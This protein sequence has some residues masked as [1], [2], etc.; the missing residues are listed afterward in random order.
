MVK[1]IILQGCISWSHAWFCNVNI[2]IEKIM[3]NEIQGLKKGF[4]IWHF[5]I[6]KFSYSYN[7]LLQTFNHKNIILNKQCCL[8]KVKEDV[9]SKKSIVKRMR[10]SII[11]VSHFARNE[12]S[13]TLKKI[14]HLQ[15]VK[16]QHLCLHKW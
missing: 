11:Q 5:L 12:M 10:K 7:A 6:L 8:S 4:K 13:G 9:H 1:S 15:K 14:C 16:S 2:W 3:K